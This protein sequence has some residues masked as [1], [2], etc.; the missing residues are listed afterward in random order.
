V[1]D[2]LTAAGAETPARRHPE[3]RMSTWALPIA[4]VLLAIVPM[5]GGSIRLA[6]LAGDVQITPD[7]DHVFITTPIP[8]VGHIV[9]ACL[10]SVVGAFQFSAGLRRRRRGWHRASGRLLVPVGLAAALSA[11][12]MTLFYPTPAGTGELL[13]I[14]R[15]VFGTA[16][17]VAL[18]LGLSA[19]LRREVQRHR[20][21]MIRAYAIGLGAGTQIFTI[22]IGEAILGQG[23]VTHDLLMTSGWAINLVVAEWAIRRSRL[24][25]RR[26]AAPRAVEL[27]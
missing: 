12:W 13:Y 8:I 20:M 19:I 27:P 10:Y 18:V 25:S 7:N 11:L 26:T 9:S 21:W 1:S 17:A 6:E 5:V 2:Q 24:R 4:L 15:L 22:G 3:T 23:V 16:M 14:A